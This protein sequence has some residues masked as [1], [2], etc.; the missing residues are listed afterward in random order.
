MKHLKRFSIVVI[1]SILVC[2][3]L[4]IFQ[5]QNEE[6]PIWFKV[7]S[8]VARALGSNFIGVIFGAIVLVAARNRVDGGL[9]VAIIICTLTGI[10]ST[11]TIYRTFYAENDV[12]IIHNTQNFTELTQEKMNNESLKKIE[13]YW[14]SQL[15]TKIDKSSPKNVI[16]SQDVHSESEY[17]QSKKYKLA[18]VKVQ[19]S[20]I[21]SAVIISG[22]IENKLQTVGCTQKGNK[23]PSIY[24]GVCGKSIEEMFGEI[25]R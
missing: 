13:L 12:H 1:V 15:K 21:V 7:A 18:V 6:W 4:A 2:V 19:I 3:P 25:K 20:N 23:F 14:V 16:S 11:Y 24:S 22:I 5:I 8:V 9:K 17:I 10:E